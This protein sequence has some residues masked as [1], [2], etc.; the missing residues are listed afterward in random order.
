MKNVMTNKE[1]LNVIS[2]LYDKYY[3]LFH[4]KASMFTDNHSEIDD[5]LH[6]AF[7]K[8]II[9]KEKIAALDIKEQ[10]PYVCAIISNTGRDYLKAKSKCKFVYADLTDNIPDEI[11][12]SPEQIIAVNEDKE[13]SLKC[14]YKLDVKDRVLLQL[15]YFEEYDAEKIA[16]KL[17]IK[18]KHIHQYIFRAKKRLVKLVQKEL[19]QYEKK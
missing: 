13:L 5:I 3:P 12:V 8:V 14:F 9:N 4:K 15:Y 19:K 18:K 17:H 1:S 2:Q 16:S 10:L 7:V 6:D 11:N